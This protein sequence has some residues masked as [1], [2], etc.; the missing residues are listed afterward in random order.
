MES[1][2]GSVQSVHI[3]QV[4]TLGSKGKMSAINKR[5]VSGRVFVSE[6]GLDGDEQADLKNH[7]GRY[8]AVHLYPSEHYAKWKVDLPELKQ[9]FTPGGFGE[10]L[11][12][13]GLTEN[14][15]CV[16][17]VY[18]LGEAL[19]RITQGRKPCWKLDVRFGIPGMAKRVLRSGRTGWYFSVIQKGFIESG[20]AIELVERP[21]PSWN[22]ARLVEYLLSPGPWNPETLTE[23]VILGDLSPNWR[24]I[25]EKHLQ[26]K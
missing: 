8:M 16:G 10:N 22:I 7:G 4:E 2:S 12:T 21:N 6:S 3:G 14:N 13:V 15:A 26:G 17:D 5:P 25:A 11:S 18:K 9:K 20:D 24:A 23:L 1:T 19:L